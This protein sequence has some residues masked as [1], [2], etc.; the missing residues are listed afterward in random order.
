M[1]KFQEPTPSKGNNKAVK[2]K[3]EIRK[4]CKSVKITLFHLGNPETETFWNK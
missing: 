4:T 3:K 2:A 1:Q